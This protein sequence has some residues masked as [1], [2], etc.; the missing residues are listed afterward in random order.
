MLDTAIT[1]ESQMNNRSVKISKLKHRNRT[2][3]KMIKA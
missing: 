2:K 1:T 3:A